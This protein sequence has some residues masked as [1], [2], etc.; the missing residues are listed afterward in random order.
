M[1]CY[2]QLIKNRVV[3]KSGSKTVLTKS[4]HKISLW[5]TPLPSRDETSINF[6]FSTCCYRALLVLAQSSLMKSSTYTSMN[7]SIHGASAGWFTMGPKS[8]WSS[9]EPLISGDIFGPSSQKIS[10]TNYVPCSHFLSILILPA[11]LNGKFGN[12]RNINSTAISNWFWPHC[13][14]GRNRTLINRNLWH[15]L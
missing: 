2:L 12:C 14:L 3:K 11:A 6:L 4:S 7:D 10:G 1:I 9:I 13:G 5:N 8:F 15:N